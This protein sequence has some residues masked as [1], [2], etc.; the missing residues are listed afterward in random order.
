ML[1]RSIDL[2]ASSISL[3]AQDA[4]QVVNASGAFTFGT[5]TGNPGPDDVG[6]SSSSGLGSL[7]GAASVNL[8]SRQVS[9]LLSGVSLSGAS[10]AS[11][12]LS[13]STSPS[14]LTMA[15]AI[16]L[17]KGV[18]GGTSLA[19]PGSVALNL[20]GSAASATS[21][22]VSD[23]TAPAL[24]QLSISAVDSGDAVAYAGTF[25]LAANPLIDPADADATTPPRTTTVDTFGASVAIN[26]L[27]GSTSAA[28]A[29]SSL[30]TA[31]TPSASSTI[32]APSI[33]LNAASSGV[34]L[35]KIGRA[36]V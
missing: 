14:S 21:A 30:S 20:D 7:A 27:S 31:S 36:H 4:T 13:S 28:L 24:N 15:G 9:T 17:S 1:F 11:V 19:I 3:S 5:R 34:D 26:D 8:I 10:P 12:S 33:S 16:S 25:G 2:G 6:D 23:L 18:A 32:T 35:I 22:Q 29:A